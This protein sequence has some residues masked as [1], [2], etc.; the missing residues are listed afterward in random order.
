M[1]TEVVTPDPLEGLF[2]NVRAG[3]AEE[4]RRVIGETP[5]LVHAYDPNASCCRATLL[6]VA[7]SNGDRAMID[8]LLELGADINQK[9][10]WWAGGFAP[11]HSVPMAHRPSLAGFLIER[12]ATVDVHAAA[13]HGLIDRLTELLD[14]QPFRVNQPVGDGGRPLHFAATREV[15]ELLIERGALL[16]PLDV[17]HGSTPAQWAARERSEV[18]RYLLAQGAES[19]PF[20]LVAIDDQAMLRSLLEFDFAAANATLSPT[21]FPSP[22]SEAGHIYCYQLGPYSSTLL[23]IA[24]AL[25]RRE[26]VTL[27]VEAGAGLNTRGGYDESTALHVAAWN[28]HADGVEHLVRLGASLEQ[29]SGSIHETT[30]LGWALLS[31]KPD[32]V[33]RLLTLGAKVLPS[34][35]TDLTDAAQGKLD[36]TAGTKE[37]FDRIAELLGGPTV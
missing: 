19:D 23:H 30:P 11:I 31:G 15:A 8:A 32:V 6:N 37:D 24:A 27:L 9:S 26:I 3:R 12:G 35:K 34:H 29:T 5:D 1:S 16:E 28:G 4:V 10:D 33:E 22:G 36:F 18:T 20:M 13:C 7:T 25:D 14:D 17:D 21:V 2:A